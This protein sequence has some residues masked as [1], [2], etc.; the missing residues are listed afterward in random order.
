MPPLSPVENYQ[1]QD[2]PAIFIKQCNRFYAMSF[3]LVP[4]LES[5]NDL[6]ACD[7]PERVLSVLRM[8]AGPHDTGEAEKIIVPAFMSMLI[9]SGLGKKFNRHATRAIK[10]AI[11]VLQTDK[12]MVTLIQN[13]FKDISE[14]SWGAYVENRA[15][16]SEANCLD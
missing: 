3:L 14:D 7:L 6:L 15:G 11:K 12:R 9:Q 2:T 4:Q 8:I 10:K 1:Q 13:A 16:N 5:F